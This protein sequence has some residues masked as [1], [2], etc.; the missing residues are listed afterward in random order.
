MIELS[1][2]QVWLLLTAAILVGG[3]CYSIGVI[4]GSRMARRVIN[5]AYA[6]GDDDARRALR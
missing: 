5:R 4:I 2:V 1:L 6:A 3:G